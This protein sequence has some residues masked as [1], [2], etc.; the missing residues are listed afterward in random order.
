MN[1]QITVLLLAVA[2][3]LFFGCTGKY[4]KFL[5]VQ[6]ET[7]IGDTPPAPP[8]EQEQNTTVTPNTP[9]TTP[10]TTTPSAQNTTLTPP[11]PSTQNTTV[12]PTIPPTPPTPTIPPTS[13]NETLTPTPSP[14]PPSPTPAQNQSAAGETVTIQPNTLAIIYFGSLGSQSS[15]LTVKKYD[16]ITENTYS[17]STITSTSTAY[18]ILGYIPSLSETYLIDETTSYS[19]S[20]S[21]LHARTVGGKVVI[22]NERGERNPAIGDVDVKNIITGE[23]MYS[24]T[25]YPQSS[26]GD[27]AI[28]GNAIY[29]T[30]PISTDLYGKRT[31]GGHLYKRDFASSSSVKLLD[32]Q[33]PPN[34]IGSLYA[35]G[36][37]LYDVR[38]S[39]DAKT[40]SRNYAVSERSTSTGEITK[41][42]TSFSYSSYATFYDGETALYFVLKDPNAEVYEVY[43][44][45]NGDAEPIFAVELEAGETGLGRLDESNG[46]LFVP[47]LSKN[48]NTLIKYSLNDRTS[49]EVNIGSLAESGSLSGAEYTLL[50]PQ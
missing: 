30:T 24:V 22:L 29:Y 27:W 31:G 14:V 12:T 25:L 7:A 45:T 6:N 42:I 19:Y 33:Y 15:S 20:R 2:L 18:A 10:G 44:I 5:E 21:T 17:L 32:Y 40:E 11:K 8:E 35:V 36:D 9:P 1:K 34:G 48:K 3:V 23:R 26:A 28:V 16:S 49:E 50:N 43:R 46:Y 4:G 38:F 39:Y 47:V 37:K 41:E 13:S